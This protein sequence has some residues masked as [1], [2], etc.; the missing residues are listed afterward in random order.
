MP[1]VPLLVDGCQLGERC[2]GEVLLTVEVIAV[3]GAGIRPEFQRRPVAGDRFVQPPL[4]LEGD[5]QI[6][7]GVGQLRRQLQGP[8]VAAHRLIQFPLRVQH[9]AQVA[10]RHGKARVEL[11]LALIEEDGLLQSSLFLQGVS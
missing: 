7:V 5:A 10:I 9:A 8:L 3:A 11:H 4:V 1:L 6:V 2:P